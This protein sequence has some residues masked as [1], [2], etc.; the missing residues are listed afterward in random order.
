MKKKAVIWIILA[1][2]FVAALAAVIVIKQNMVGKSEPRSYS[3]Q[4]NAA[5]MAEPAFPMDASDRLCGFPA[6][7]YNVDGNTVKITYGDEGYITKT[8]DEP[9]SEDDDS[10]FIETTEQDVDGRTVTFQGNDG[11]V[12]LARWQDK[13]F[14]YT[15]SVNNGVNAEEMIEYVKATN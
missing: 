6:T 10:N 3:I 7:D 14:T 11:T 15:I 1:A 2:V 8:L 9:E 13:G 4:E 12:C 5:N